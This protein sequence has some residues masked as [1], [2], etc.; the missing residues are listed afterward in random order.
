VQGAVG[1]ATPGVVLPLDTLEAPE[2]FGE[3]VLSEIGYFVACVSVLKYVLLS[4]ISTV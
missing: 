1:G 4:P 2:D 3:F